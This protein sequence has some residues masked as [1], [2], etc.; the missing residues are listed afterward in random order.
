M[1]DSNRIISR[2]STL[3]PFQLVTPTAM[4]LLYAQLIF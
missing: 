1:P 2:L 3:D 4:V